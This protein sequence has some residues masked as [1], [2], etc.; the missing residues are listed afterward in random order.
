MHRATR[1]EACGRLRGRG[2]FAEGVCG[3]FVADAKLSVSVRA[4]KSTEEQLQ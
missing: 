2:L 3:S 4:W 1:A